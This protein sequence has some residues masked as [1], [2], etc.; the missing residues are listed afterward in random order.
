MRY[1]ADKK[2]RRYHWIVSN[3]PVHHGAKDDFSVVE[4]LIKGSWGRLRKQG[5]LWIVAQSYIPLKTLATITAAGDKWTSIEVMMA[6]TALEVAP[7]VLMQ[8]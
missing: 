8:Q 3:P 6:D 7:P 2:K 5:T 1:Q 4:R